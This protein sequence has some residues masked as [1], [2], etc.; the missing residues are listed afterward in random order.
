LNN[1]GSEISGV[2]LLGTSAVPVYLVG[3]KE[4]ILIE[5][6]VSAIV[7]ELADQ[8]IAY[9][10]IKEGGGGSLRRLLLT[11]SHFDHCGAVAY[12]QANIPSLEITASPEAAELLSKPKVIQF[13]RT[14]NARMVSFFGR[15]NEVAGHKGEFTRFAVVPE[16]HDG[17]FFDNWTD[18]G[19]LEIL[20]T[21]GHSRCSV[22]IWIPERRLLF[23]GDACGFFGGPG[24]V[25][26]FSLNDFY[27]QLKDVQLFKQL[28]P[29]TIGFGHFGML[30]GMDVE[31]FFKDFD[32]ATGK[33]IDI[34]NESRGNVENAVNNVMNRFYRDGFRFLQERFFRECVEK[35]VTRIIE[36]E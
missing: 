32:D 15:E 9:D 13:I 4:Q 29:T 17:A 12:L 21:P 26:P 1:P 25:F 22:S 24:R 30:T 35:M 16:L 34:A 8:I 36:V 10:L 31:G 19:T 18:I 11:H 14:E 5:G 27:Q 28:D 20:S 3:N 2:R 7:P 33:L 23:V 6:G